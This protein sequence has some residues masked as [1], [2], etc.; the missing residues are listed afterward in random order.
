MSAL[1]TRSVALTGTDQA[2]LDAPGDY[3]GYTVRE[4]SGADPVVVDIYDDPDSADGTLL[5]CIAL[6]VGESKRAY[7]PVGLAAT[8]GVYVAVT[9]DGAVAG[10]VRVG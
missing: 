7:W 10:S 6:A 9:G 2:V 3:R 8:T 1:R 5:E 4:T